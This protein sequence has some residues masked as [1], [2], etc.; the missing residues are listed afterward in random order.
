[1]LLS[2][3]IHFNDY[4]NIISICINQKSAEDRLSILCIFFSYLRCK[5]FH[6]YF[7]AISE[8]YVYQTKEDFFMGMQDKVQSELSKINNEEKDQILENFN[9][10]KQF[11]SEKVQL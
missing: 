5:F 10:F 3:F 4:R 2:Y 1:E 9:R 11:L 8:I 6:V 7:T